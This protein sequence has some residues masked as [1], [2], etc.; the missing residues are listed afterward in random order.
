MASETSIVNQALALI[1]QQ[2]L[3]SLNDSSPS[4]QA[5]ALVFS[6]I[7]DAVLR[8]HKWNFAATRVKLA[9]LAETPISEWV[10]CYQLPSDF[11]RLLPTENEAVY[12][13]E[14]RKI[15][16]NES[17]LI[18]KYIKQE[19]DTNIYDPMFVRALIHRLGSELAN[20]I[21]GS[22]S[23]SNDLYEKYS[24]LL[25]EARGV[26]AREGRKQKFRKTSW[27]KARR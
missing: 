12:E 18:I 7:R 5:A 4:A 13:V 20:T 15:L 6:D 11:I 16:S 26:D 9:R 25:A 17:E 21:A 1:G 22:V 27:V 14:G 10:Y 3:S 24:R 8:D 2:K 23:L 19:K